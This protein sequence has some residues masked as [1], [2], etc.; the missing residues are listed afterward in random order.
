MPTM[1]IETEQLLSAALQLPRN[2]LENFV[3]QL[4]VRKARAETPCLAPAETEL[5]S[6]ISQ[7]IPPQAR[8]RMNEL[9]GRRHAGSITQEEL[10]ELIQLTDYAEDFNAERMKHLFALSA[11]RNVPLDELMQQLNIRPLGDR[12]SQYPER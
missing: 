10:A 2:E 4:F 6:K 9:I 3:R 12:T 7:D 1:Q 8:R 11:L 5:L